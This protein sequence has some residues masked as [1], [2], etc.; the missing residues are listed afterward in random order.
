M[1]GSAP[2]PHPEHGRLAAEHALL[3]DELARLLAEAHDLEHIVKPNLLALYQTKI[4]AWELRQLEAE[5]ETARLRRKLELV[6]AALN[7][8]APPDLPAI[9]VALA[10]EEMAWRKRLEEAAEAIRIAECRLECLLS[11]ED[12]RALK[13]CYRALVKALHPDLNPA[14]PE[15]QRL[16]WPRVQAAYAVG[17]IGELRALVLLVEQPGE[18]AP[19]SATIEQ[20][21]QEG[22]TLRRQIAR[23][24]AD[25]ERIRSQPPFPL[26]EQLADGAWVE[27]RRLEIERRIAG[28][29]QRCAALEAQLDVLL[30]DHGG[31]SFIGQN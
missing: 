6:Q 22:E 24:L 3:R 5:F 4:G 10:F 15:D 20:L 23:V 28:L 9:E 21:L 18:T 29:Q 31:R 1:N 11:P 30:K 12:D 8:G 19:A 7:C 17:D 16:L 14:L 27:A 26:R 25:L 2:I 13:K